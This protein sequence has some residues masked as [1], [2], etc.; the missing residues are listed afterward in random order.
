VVRAIDRNDFR[1]VD[2]FDAQVQFIEHRDAA[3]GG[4]F[5]NVV[6]DRSDGRQEVSPLAF[7]ELENGLVAGG[8]PAPGT[9]ASDGRG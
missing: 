7:L 3:E 8:G 1:L 4:Q 5:L 6:S 2:R 9:P